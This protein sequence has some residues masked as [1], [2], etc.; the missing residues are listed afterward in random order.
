[1]RAPIRASLIYSQS[2]VKNFHLSLRTS[3]NI[4]NGNLPEIS[5]ETLISCEAKLQRNL[6]IPVNLNSVHVL[7]W[8]FLSNN[9]LH[10]FVFCLNTVEI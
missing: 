6:A 4:P 8:L 5:S 7:I 2:V 3:K 1:M 9:W 10:V